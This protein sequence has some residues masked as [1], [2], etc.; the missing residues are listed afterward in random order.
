M[1]SRHWAIS[2]VALAALLVAIPPLVGSKHLFT[3]DQAV[4]DKGGKG[5]NGGGNS[6][7]HGNSGNKG[8]G[9]STNSSASGSKSKS[10]KASV[11]T[12]KIKKVK[13]AVS[14]SA[15]ASAEEDDEDVDVEAKNAHG[16]LAS[17]MGALNAAHASAQA[18][19]NASPNSRVGR[20][21]AYYE[22]N[23]E[24]MASQDAAMASQDAFDQAFADSAYTQE[25]Y[26]AV[27][28]AYDA[29]QDN[30][31][32]PDLQDAYDQAL[33]ENSVEQGTFEDL[34]D[35]ESTA[36]QDAA[37]ASEDADAAMSL[38]EAAAN[39]PV[40][41]EVKAEVDRLLEGKIPD[42]PAAEDPAADSADSDV[43]DTSEP[44]D[45]SGDG[46]EEEEVVTAN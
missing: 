40:D 9:K 1:K 17:K 26:D 23:R 4:A 41:D 7:G 42:P 18:F 27:K 35:K 43:T 25:Q 44:G 34:A 16:K 14:A 20:I 24:A 3:F 33:T 10:A 46:I 32:D 5:G 28:A 36:L 29:L 11:A 13:N 38:L 45:D 30:P 2:T 12:T 8:G 15:V 19:A 6:G 37:T 39:K 21:R 31:D 22:A